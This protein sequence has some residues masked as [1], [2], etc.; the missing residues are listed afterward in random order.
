[1]APTEVDLLRALMLAASADHELAG[2]RFRSR[3]VAEWTALVRR[4]AT[5]ADLGW[6]WLHPQA[7]ATAAEDALYAR[8]D[9]WAAQQGARRLVSATD[10]PREAASLRRARFRHRGLA[11]NGVR[12][13]YARPCGL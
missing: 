5:A 8:A 2:A 13:V 10:D 7:E 1:M 9:E 6:W 11:A 12:T 3:T 4:G